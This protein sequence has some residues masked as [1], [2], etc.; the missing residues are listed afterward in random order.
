VP[1]SAQRKELSRKFKA[2]IDLE[3]LC[4][5]W[6]HFNEAQNVL[7]G[8][9]RRISRINEKWFAWAGEM[10]ANLMKKLV[11]HFFHRKDNSSKRMKKTPDPVRIGVLGCG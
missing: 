8:S 3:L 4:Q 7:L 5:S 2:E 1:A 6:Q 9:L 11:H 10:I